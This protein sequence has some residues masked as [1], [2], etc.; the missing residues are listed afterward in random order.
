[1]GR[2]DSNRGFCFI[3]IVHE[4]FSTLLLHKKDAGQNHKEHVNTASL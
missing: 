3:G 2:K 1:M 4:K